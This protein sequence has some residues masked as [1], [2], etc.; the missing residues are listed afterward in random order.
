MKTGSSVV[1]PFHKSK[2]PQLDVRD[3]SRG[4]VYD[5]KSSMAKESR[6]KEIL[7]EFVNLIR[8]ASNKFSRKLVGRYDYWDFFEEGLF[9][10]SLC[11]CKWKDKDP[12][13]ED[14]NS[15]SK[16]FKTSL[17][18]RFRQVQIKAFT[19]KRFG[20]HVPLEFASQIS[21][22]GGF[23]DV[24]YRELIDHVISF[25]NKDEEKIFQLM[26]NPPE[27]LVSDAINEMARKKKVALINGTYD[28][29]TVKLTISCLFKYINKKEHLSESGFLKSLR[30]VRKK[31][32]DIVTEKE[33]VWKSVV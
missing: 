8:W 31:V 15:F 2:E 14:L 20:V 13:S 27:D 10:L 12:Q 16:Y 21:C 30:S 11:L 3:A 9:I 18:R 5:P 29:R 28:C 23:N 24:H 25:L 6:E 7:Q 19:K 17:F 33:D 26:V 22:D 4:K 1:I 32:K